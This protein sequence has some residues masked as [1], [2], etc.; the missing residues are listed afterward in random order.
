M[1]RLLLSF[2]FCFASAHADETGCAEDTLAPSADYLLECDTANSCTCAAGTPVPQQFYLS[3]PLSG[4]HSV[5]K[6]SSGEAAVDLI[7]NAN[8]LNRSQAI[9]G[10]CAS[11][12]QVRSEYG[13]WFEEQLRSFPPN[14]GYS[15]RTSARVVN[16]TVSTALLSGPNATCSMSM[17]TSASY[18]AFALLMQR[19]QSQNRLPGGLAKLTELSGGTQTEAWFY[20]NDI[21]RPDMA[22]EAL[23]LGI[24]R[25]MDAS[26]I[27]SCA[28]KGWPRSGDFVQ[29]WRKN[30][31]GHSVV[32]S[33]YLKNAAGLITGICYW[34]SNQATNG[35]AHRC[36]AIENIDKLIVGRVTQ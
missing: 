30:A 12:D 8:D 21:A 19:L 28:N 17:C 6:C 1:I 29:I 32:F 3:E 20:F 31:S 14:C 35:F 4:R 7:S 11:T 25:R 9:T 18:T 24:G 16:H 27:E 23:G 34:S 36:E 22:M 2:L 15:L 10:P 13:P 5:S 26:E 33:G